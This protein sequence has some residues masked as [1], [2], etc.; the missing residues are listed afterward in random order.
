MESRQPTSP[1]YD[2]ESL[3]RGVARDVLVRENAPAPKVP[4]CE[5]LEEIGRGGQGVVYSAE[6]T[7]TKR[8][9]AVKVLRDAPGQS[10][11][12]RLRFEREVEIVA[13]LRDPRLV[14]VFGGGSL[15]DGRPFV[16]MELVQGVQLD[17]A[18]VVAEARA[19][20]FARPAADA[21]IALFADTCDAMDHAH[22]HGVIH[23]DLKP[24][25]I[26]VDAAGAPRVLDFG[27]AKA[28]GLAGEGI[29]F[30]TSTGAHFAGSLPWTS[31]EQAEGRQEAVDVRS[32]VYALGA[33]LYHAV[34]GTPPCPLDRDLRKTLDAIV[35]E[36]PPPLDARCDRD[37]A[38]VILRALE[39]DPAHR[40]ATAGA[41][42]KDLRGIL[43]GEPIEARRDNA[44][45]ALV[46]LARRRKRVAILASVLAAAAIA[47][48]VLVASFWRKADAESKRAAAAL[49]FFL[50]SIGMVDPGRDGAN[51]KLV[52]ALD[53]ISSQLDARIPETD[54]ESRLKLRRRLR[55]LFLMLGRYDKSLAEAEIVS[56]ITRAQDPPPP[57]SEFRSRWNGE[58]VRAHALY[59]LARK[60]DALA[61][62]REA[63]GR[64]LGAFGPADSDVLQAAAAS[65]Q[66]M[67]S[68]GRLPEAL[69][70]LRGI[71]SAT[72]G[73]RTAAEGA[74]ARAVALD[75]IAAI[76]EMQG[77]PAKAEAPQ[78]ESNDLFAAIHGEDAPQVLVGRSNLG[79]LYLTLGR[80]QDAVQ[81]LA[82]T[83]ARFRERSGPRHPMTLGAFHNLGVAHVR[84]GR[85][86]DG[87]RVLR[88]VYETR[89]AD[90]GPSAK[91]TQLTRRQL[92]EALEAAGDAAGA[93][94]IEREAAASRRAESTKTADSR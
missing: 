72:G 23:R 36:P 49:D 73:A 1:W 90:L 8:R 3:L 29:G 21:A 68:L 82:P 62:Y 94:R 91:D 63:H 74:L 14:Q 15:E 24:S 11:S 33:T 22:R 9:V 81:I 25:N 50:D 65:A 79:N 64:L 80:P 86:G 89:L 40:Y 75:N 55:D 7:A 70:M 67:K 30:A 54:Q 57:S 19:A 48:V 69:E 39:K 92:V 61:A 12:A 46:K 43:A 32:D 93:A 42:A 34:S 17:R 18:P 41:I 78:K 53:R 59:R 85:A 76:L 66:A 84:A 10:G 71:E 27:L 2:D 45:R 13:S 26:L 87:V 35:K 58:V 60:E 51:T 6:Q 31:P 5:R 28:S 56:A 77:E 37:L 4:G 52:D 20:G 16:V 47:V 44:W 38:A 88:E 83:A